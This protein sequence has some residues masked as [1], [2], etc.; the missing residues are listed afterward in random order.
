MQVAFTPEDDDLN[1]SVSFRGTRKH[2]SEDEKNHI[3]TQLMSQA[4]NFIK[5]EIPVFSCEFCIIFKN[6][7]VIE[8]LRTIA[9]C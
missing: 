4:G 8:H 1:I 2:I 7:F 6:A 9:S 3:I 5:K